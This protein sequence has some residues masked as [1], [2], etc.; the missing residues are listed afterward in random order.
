MKK[1]KIRFIKR[2]ILFLIVLS[3]LIIGIDAFYKNY[4]YEERRVYKK[5]LDYN[6]FISELPQKEIDFVFFG[7]SHVLHSVNPKYIPNSYNYAFGGE[8]YTETYYKFRRLLDIEKIKI[9]Y[10]VFELDLNTFTINSEDR[11]FHL[12]HIDI[13]SKFVSY[14]DIKDI[15][16][17]SLFN[18]WI[19]SHFPFI[20][21][22]LILSERFKS[23]TGLG[24]TFYK[25]WNSLNLSWEDRQ[26]NMNIS[27]QPYISLEILDQLS[28]EYF[29][30]TI[31]LA[32]NRNISI[33]FVKYPMDKHFDNRLN[34]YN[35]SRNSYY[36]E[37][38]SAIDPILGDDYRVLDYYDLYFNEPLYFADQVHLN[39][40]GAEN[41]S[42]RIYRD[43]LSIDENKSKETA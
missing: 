17:E 32:Q 11:A 18:V 16:N 27:D 24:N 19:L 28:F 2:I 22:G 40:L 37:I 42:I 15:R 9:N 7:D 12:K 3:I 23:A 35:L 20:G 4:V 34:K 14:K 21:D 13:Y 38:F 25:G 39:L 30:H 6:R 1:E 29:I 8:K 26:K 41:F 36:N 33:V 10:A 43:L 31:K 5:E